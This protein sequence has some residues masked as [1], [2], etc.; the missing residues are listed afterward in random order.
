MGSRI[1]IA[2]AA[3]APLLLV[4]CEEPQEREPQ[5]PAAGIWISDIRRA[6]TLEL[7]ENGDL[8]AREIGYVASGTW[9]MPDADTILLKVTRINGGRVDVPREYPAHVVELTANRLCL[10]TR[11]EVVSGCFTRSHGRRD[12][13]VPPSGS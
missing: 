5:S 10:R 7:Y 12:L 1:G 8:V 6:T 13:A 11:Y 3:L 4:A 9:L 2:I